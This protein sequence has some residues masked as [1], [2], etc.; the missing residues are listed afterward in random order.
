MPQDPIQRWEWEGGAV[1]VDVSAG[2]ER[3][4]P[5]SGRLDEVTAS[6]EHDPQQAP[7]AQPR[8]PRAIG[9]PSSSAVDANQAQ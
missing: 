5:A 3:R 1:A 9:V 7:G 2:A 4:D 6:Q 8:S